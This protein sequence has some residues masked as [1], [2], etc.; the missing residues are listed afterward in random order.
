MAKHALRR[1]RLDHIVVDNFLSMDCANDVVL[2]AKAKLYL[3]LTRASAEETA[4]AVFKTFI[5][6]LPG[7]TMLRTA[8]SAP[9]VTWALPKAQRGLQRSFLPPH[10]QNST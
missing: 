10:W 8:V 5:P 2:G 7:D 9:I 6:D 3:A 4:T 1:H